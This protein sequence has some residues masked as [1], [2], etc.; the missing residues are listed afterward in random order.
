MV[1]GKKSKE[2]VKRTAKARK[3]YEDGRFISKLK[4]QF[5][6]EIKKW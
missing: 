5:L 6:K 1:R 2:F 4:R 3:E